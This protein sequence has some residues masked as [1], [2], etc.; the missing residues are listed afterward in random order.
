[1]FINRL[2]EIRKNQKLTQTKLAELCGLSRTAINEIENGVTDPKY[3]TV[4]KIS[5]VLGTKPEEIFLPKGV[6]NETALETIRVRGAKYRG[7]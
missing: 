5:N 2:K 6:I 4:L 3:S 7:K 1:M